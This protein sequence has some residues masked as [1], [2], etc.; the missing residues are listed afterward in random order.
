[1]NLTIYNRIASGDL[2]PYKNRLEPD[3]KSVSNKLSSVPQ[4]IYEAQEYLA[5]AIDNINF[6]PLPQETP[7]WLHSSAVYTPLQDYPF[8]IRIIQPALTNSRKE[9]LYSAV[10]RWEGYRIIET[11][12]YSSSAYRDDELTNDDVTNVLSQIKNVAG[13]VVSANAMCTDKCG[14]NIYSYFQKYLLHLYYEIYS[15]FNEIINEDRISP[16]IDF[17]GSN[18]NDEN[19]ITAFVHTFKTLQNISRH[20]TDEINLQKLYTFREAKIEISHLEDVV[21]LAEDALYLPQAPDSITTYEEL[22]SIINDKILSEQ[23]PRQILRYIESE[24]QKITNL[25]ISGNSSQSIAA[26][27]YLFLREQ[28]QI[29]TQNISSSFAPLNAVKSK[30]GTIKPKLS[31][32]DIADKKQIA[33]KYVEFLSGYNLKGEKIMSDQSYAR[34]LTYLEH[35]IEY[36][37]LPE[38]IAPIPKLGIKNG[39]LLYTFYLVHKNL[40]DTT[41]TKKIWVKFLKSVFTQLSNTEES[42]ISA[43]WHTRPQYYDYDINNKKDKK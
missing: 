15:V 22:H 35:L 19:T 40:N 6:D 8:D 10:I 3:Y 30:P 20:N 42:T 43:K 25:G 24:I 5:L 36:N 26:R 13:D 2:V 1:M 38:D 37:E 7:E 9:R 17:P 21:S 27:I 41:S 18:T 12:K 23:D 4:S 28:K 34:L 16:V 32:R 39:E 14:Y 33:R 11:L 29:Y 31:K